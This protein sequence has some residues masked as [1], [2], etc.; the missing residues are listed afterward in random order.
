MVIN[1]RHPLNL[2]GFFYF[3]NFAGLR[4]SPIDPTC[5]LNFLCRPNAAM[6]DSADKVM[7]I[8]ITQ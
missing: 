4:L 8:G 2:S 7:E 1:S 3:T 6:N 5:Y